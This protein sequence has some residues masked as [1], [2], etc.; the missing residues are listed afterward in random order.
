LTERLAKLSETFESSFPGKVGKCAMLLSEWLLSETDKKS[1]GLI[2]AMI[3]AAEK[4]RL[5]EE[6]PDTGFSLI[7]NCLPDN[8]EN[9]PLKSAIQEICNYFSGRIP[10]P[11][12]SIS[13]IICLAILLQAHLEPRNGI[14]VSIERII[15]FMRAGNLKIDLFVL[16]REVFPESIQNAR[17]WINCC[18]LLVADGEMNEFISEMFLNTSELD[19]VSFCELL[20]EIKDLKAAEI[21]SLNSI[22]YRIR[23]RVDETRPVVSTDYPDKPAREI[24]EALDDIENW[25][26]IPYVKILE[27]FNQ[28]KINIEACLI[29]LPSVLDEK[30]IEHLPRISI[31]QRLV[32]QL[33][34]LPFIQKDRTG[35][36]KCS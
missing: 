3:E 31:L 14:L 7:L 22:Y 26:G 4:T 20:R 21:D 19:V 28:Q 25:K 29:N 1:A 8:H 27:F 30:K 34:R 11:K 24:G 2:V 10:A 5:A 6:L 15:N 32:K 23:V 16:I 36:R 33:G 18:T 9:L 13:Q 12:N 35:A 17:A